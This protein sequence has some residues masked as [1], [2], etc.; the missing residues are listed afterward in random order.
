MRA[1]SKKIEAPERM[2][3]GLGLAA[4]AGR[5]RV[6]YDAVT[7][8]ARRGEAR[9]VVIAADAP[10][11]LRAKLERL[12]TARGV[13]HL[14]LLDGDRLGRAVGRERVV[15]L[16]VTDVNIGRRVLELAEMERSS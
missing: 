10:K 14:V 4:R 3:S 7:R 6:G 13:P 5:L 2:L 12:L 8:A 11:A 15:V 16:A 1:K 9:A